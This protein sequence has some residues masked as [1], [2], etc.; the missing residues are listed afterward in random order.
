MFWSLT[1]H[2]L[3]GEGII[4]SSPEHKQGIRPIYSVFL[5]NKRVLF[6]FDGLGSSMS[7]SF[8]YD[9]I[10]E[11]EPSKRLLINYIRINAKNKNYYLN[12]ANPEYWSK[13]IL[14][15]KQEMQ[16]TGESVAESSK[17]EEEMN[18]GKILEMLTYL[19]LHSI[20]TTEEFEEK[21][22]LLDSHK[23]K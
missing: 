8:F 9:E 7:Q 1:F 11:A 5:T 6:R 20:L 2:L 3:P 10:A 16:K 13:R 23:N 22:S 4:E 15:I 14:E 17:P 12:A 19:K 21:I 18:R